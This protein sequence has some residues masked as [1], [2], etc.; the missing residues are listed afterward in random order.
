MNKD[1]DIY[2]VMNPTQDYECNQ[3]LYYWFSQ[4]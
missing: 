4:E 1:D 2:S 3:K